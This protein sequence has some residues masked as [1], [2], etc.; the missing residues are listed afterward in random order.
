MVYKHLSQTGTVFDQRGSM[1]ISQ[2]GA[3]R[4]TRY[5]LGN[6]TTSRVHYNTE[7]IRD[8]ENDISA[9]EQLYDFFISLGRYHEELGYDFGNFDGAIGT[10]RDWDYAG[11]QFLFWTTGE[12]QVGNTIELSQLATKVK[13]EAPRGFIAKRIEAT[14][15]SL[16]L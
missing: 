6:G 10:V 9:E 2:L 3:A 11:Q 4:G 1:F 16:L 8:T 7:F 15:N 13:F 14:E 12:W 5:R